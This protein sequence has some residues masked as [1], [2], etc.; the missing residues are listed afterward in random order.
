MAF[1]RE[2]VP[3]FIAFADFYGVH[4]ATVLIS[5]IQCDSIEPGVGNICSQLTDEAC[6]G[7]SLALL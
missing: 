7:T 1:W 2:K 6:V 5:R 4:T 3:P